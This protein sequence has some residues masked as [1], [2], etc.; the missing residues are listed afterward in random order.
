MQLV[1]HKHS[2]K[3]ANSIWP[4]LILTRADSLDSDEESLTWNIHWES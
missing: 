3:P 4:M 2:S 1:C